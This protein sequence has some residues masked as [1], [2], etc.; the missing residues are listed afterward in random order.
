MPSLRNQSIWK[1]SPKK[2]RYAVTS[3]TFNCALLF[4]FKMYNILLINCRIKV[5]AVSWANTGVSV[6]WLKTSMC[7]SRMPKRTMSRGHR[8][9]RWVCPW[10]YDAVHSLNL[11]CIPMTNSYFPGCKHHQKDFCTKEVWAG[12]W[13]TNQVQHSHQVNRKH[14]WE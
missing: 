5:F 14:H 10:V 3:F 2:F 8:C 6:P 1:S 4:I 7:L 13:R 12:T 9:L 11:T